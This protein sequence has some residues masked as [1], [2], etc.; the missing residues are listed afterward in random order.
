MLA[1]ADEMTGPTATEPPTTIEGLV[2]G[3]ARAAVPHLAAVGF[4][5]SAAGYLLGYASVWLFSTGV[6]IAPRDLGLDNRDYLLLAAV[7]AFL[8]GAYGASV[9]VLLFGG[10]SYGTNLLITLFDGLVVS[11]IVI[12]LRP[13]AGI[14]CL[15]AVPILGAA[16][17]LHVRHRELRPPSLFSR[18]A[19]PTVAI[20]VLVFAGW[21]SVWWG[22]QVRD[23]PQKARAGP[24]S[25]M[26]VVPPT[27]GVVT[28][29][30]DPSCVMRLSDRVY[31]TPDE[32]IVTPEAQL[33][34][35]TTCL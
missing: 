34:R 21:S 13:A 22:Q 14:S 28:L 25:L 27:E 2:R 24:I 5:L 4:A 7:W 17:F 33:F 18:I 10:V 3:I 1:G 26:L 15:L 31:I 32:V 9:A 8:I 30:S 12:P 29:D 19:V 20:G 6:G 11:I 35:P 16:L 23:D